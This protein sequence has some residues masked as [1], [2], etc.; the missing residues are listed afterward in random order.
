MRDSSAR[1]GPPTIESRDDDIDSRIRLTRLLH[2]HSAASIATGRLIPDIDPRV[3]EMEGLE[4]V[5]ASVFP[6]A[7]SR[8]PQDISYSIAKDWQ[9]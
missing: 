4:V 6:V 2:A 5:D 3:K 9:T 7:I 8:H 1:A